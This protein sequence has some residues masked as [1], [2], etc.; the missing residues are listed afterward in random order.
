MTL[1]NLK[2]QIYGMMN[3]SSSVLTTT[4][5]A[6]I[7]QVLYAINAARRS[8]QRAHTFELNRKDVFLTTSEVGANWMT[9]CKTTPGGATAVLMKRVDEVYNY[10]SQTVAAGTVYARSTR[11]DYGRPA[12]FRDEVPV[13]PGAVLDLTAS[14][15]TLARRKFAYVNGVNLHI[16][17]VAIAAP[18]LLNGISFLDDLADGDSP[19]LFLTYFPDWLLWASIIQLNQFLKDTERLPVDMTFVA[20]LWETVKQFDGDVAN[21]GDVASL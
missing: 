5:G 21:A 2:A 9:G 20:R 12:S 3:R 11:I 1:A 7:D 10:N 14:S 15:A 8:A 6:T 17:T 13:D 19:D 4:E 18:V 16:V